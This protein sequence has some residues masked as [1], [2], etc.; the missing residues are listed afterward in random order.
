MTENPQGPIVL[1]WGEMEEGEFELLPRGPHAA[2]IFEVELRDSQSSPYPYLNVDFKLQDEPYQNRHAWSIWSLHPKALPYGV[3]RYCA[4]LGIELPT[5]QTVNSYS[6]F[7]QWLIPQL[8][9]KPCV[10][11]I[12][13]EEYEGRTRER[14][15]DVLPAGS[16]VSKP[17]Q[18]SL[19]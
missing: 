12:G 7:A 8:L 18:P 4:R 10:V 11:V 6:E 19:I 17:A 3:K 2:N 13:H 5:S 1:G 15:N 14:V 9:G 16:Q